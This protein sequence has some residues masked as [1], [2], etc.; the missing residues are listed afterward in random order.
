MQT[1]FDVMGLFWSESWGA[2]YCACVTHHTRHGLRV[3]SYRANT[4]RDLRDRMHRDGWR[5]PRNVGRLCLKCR[6]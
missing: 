2:R 5:A 1:R 6:H 4:A 3:A